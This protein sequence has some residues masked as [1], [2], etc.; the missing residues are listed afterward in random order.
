[1][2]PS[3]VRSDEIEVNSTS[4]QNKATKLEIHSHEWR[5]PQGEMVTRSQTETIVKPLIDFKGDMWN[6]YIVVV[7]ITSC[8]SGI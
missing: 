4:Y 1:V 8:H 2:R 5:N 7:Y 6:D 3:L